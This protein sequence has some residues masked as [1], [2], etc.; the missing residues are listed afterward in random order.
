[1][2]VL[3]DFLVAPRT[4]EA[5]ADGRATRRS[6]TG[7]ALDDRGPWAG[8]S[9]VDDG[10]PRREVPFDRPTRRSRSVRAPA[11]SG[12]PPALGVLAPER[13]L[14]AA[15]AGVGLAVGRSAPAVLVCLAAPAL[16]PALRA[17]AR[18]A[19]ARLAASLRARGLEA[20]ARGRLAFVHLPD[21]ERTHAVT[22]AM[23]A[24]DGLPT[25]LAVAGRDEEVDALLAARDAILVALP[26]SAD[27][28]LAH[29][30]LAGAAALAPA[31]AAVTLAL[32]P[33]QRTLALAGARAPR[34]LVAAV[35]ELFV[36]RQA[37]A[38]L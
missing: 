22:R 3:R 16:S 25:V 37:A 28:A 24:A 38:A 32:D 23:A 27:P 2:R 31:A 36:A 17:P 8:E 10:N 4:G 18:T 33:V 5:E 13:D 35:P 15:A 6:R 34:A 29:L 12:A 30:A 14:P 20:S 26:P 11:S 21:A 7:E 9:A 1:M 19:A